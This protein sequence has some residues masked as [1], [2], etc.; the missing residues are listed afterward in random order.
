ML[1]G[2]KRLS[3]SGQAD[4]KDME[5][6]LKIKDRSLGSSEGKVHMQPGSAL[7]KRSTSGSD[8]GSLS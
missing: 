6:D 3:G 8:S 7:A 4:K 5:E 1:W 2:E